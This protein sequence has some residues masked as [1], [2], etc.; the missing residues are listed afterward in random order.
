MAQRLQISDREW[1]IVADILNRHLSGKN[2]WA[3]GSRAT[4]KNVKRFSDLDIAV[5]GRLTWEER[6]ALSEALDEALI[7]F[8]VDV[9]ELDLVDADFKERIEKDFVV[10]Q[11]RSV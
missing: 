4:G 6:A 7:N 10:L 8:K 2:A 5:P 3:F 1:G 11:A 9:V